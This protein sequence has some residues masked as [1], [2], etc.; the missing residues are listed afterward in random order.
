MTKIKA[1]KI[2]ISHW[3]EPYFIKEMMIYCIMKIF[4]NLRYLD[5]TNNLHSVKGLIPRNMDLIKAR[6]P[7]DITEQFL[8]YASKIPKC[9]VENT[10]MLYENLPSTIR[11]IF[12]FPSGL[13]NSSSVRPSN[14]LFVN[15]GIIH[16]KNQLTIQD[17]VEDPYLLAFVNFKKLPEPKTKIVKVLLHKYDGFAFFL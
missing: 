15:S 9:N 7:A 3:K 6:Q 11:D 4:L 2:S 1:L 13:G 12:T 16:D 8:K 10:I 17:N 14:H 5:V